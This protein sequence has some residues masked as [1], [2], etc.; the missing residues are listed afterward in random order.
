MVPIVNSINF[1]D[2]T[3]SHYDGYFATVLDDVFTQEECATL[4]SLAAASAPWSPA[5][6]SAEGPTQTVHSDF[7]N[8]ERILYINAET[9][10][11]ICERVRPLIE[12]DIGEIKVGGKWDGITGKK[13]RNQGPAW[14]LAG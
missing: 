14:R 4:L 13:G 8:S 3:L 2:T 12:S 6:I 10:N 9:A 7:R 5:G 11:M 1:A